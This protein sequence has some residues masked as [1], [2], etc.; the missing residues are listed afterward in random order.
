[1]SLAARTG[2]VLGTTTGSGPFWISEAVVFFL[3]LAVFFVILPPRGKRGKKLDFPPYSF[4][5]YRPRFD[6]SKL[7]IYGIS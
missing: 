2:S 4:D 3:F 1:M 5:D 7:G 6:G